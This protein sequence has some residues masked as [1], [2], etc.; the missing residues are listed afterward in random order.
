MIEIQPIA[1]PEKPPPLTR[2]EYHKKWRKENAEHVRA[3]SKEW[4][5]NNP[6]LFKAMQ[7]KCVYGITAEQWNELFEKQG[8]CC[9]ICKKTEPGKKRG[10]HTDHNHVTNKV[11]GILCASC[12][13]RLAAIE[14]KEFFEAAIAYLERA[15]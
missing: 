12:N 11:R 13:R 10:W 3:K 2:K 14:D 9:A 4:R 8:C 15:T 7:R 1:L 5:D 6:E